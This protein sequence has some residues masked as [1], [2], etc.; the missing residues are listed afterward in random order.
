MSALPPSL[1]LYGVSPQHFFKT[2]SALDEALSNSGV[3][4]GGI[5]VSS[6]EIIL[7]LSDVSDSRLEDFRNRVALMPFA[8]AYDATCRNFPA[9]KPSAGL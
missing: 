1:T 6:S 3:P 5:T 4:L 2:M 9:L 7:T 8:N